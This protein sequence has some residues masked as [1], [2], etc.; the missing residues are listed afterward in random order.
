VAVM[1]EALEPQTLKKLHKA[2]NQAKKSGVTLAHL[3]K[4]ATKKAGRKRMQRKVATKRAAAASRPT[5]SKAHARKTPA[6][7]KRRRK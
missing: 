2:K 4:R 6:G 3:A 1:V 7:V 5:K